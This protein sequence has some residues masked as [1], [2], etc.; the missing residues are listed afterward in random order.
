MKYYVRLALKRAAL[1]NLKEFQVNVHLI[2][3]TFVVGCSHKIDQTICYSACDEQ[4]LSYLTQATTLL[5]MEQ[6]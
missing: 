3:D 4:L 2:H 6:A 5:N 1:L